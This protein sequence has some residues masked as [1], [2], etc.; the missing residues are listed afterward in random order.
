VSQY[1]H[2]LTILPTVCPTA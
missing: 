1:H 2:T